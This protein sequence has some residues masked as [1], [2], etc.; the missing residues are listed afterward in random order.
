MSYTVNTLR[1]IKADEGG[2]S[3]EIFLIMGAD[4]YAF[5]DRWREPHSIREL[6]K[7]VV[8]DREGSTGVEEVGVIRV[9]MERV[10]ISSTEVRARIACGDSIRGWVPNGVSLLIEREGLYRS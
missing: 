2:E 4:Q 8:L 10:D 3:S 9:P 6:A 5:F 1:E 7:I